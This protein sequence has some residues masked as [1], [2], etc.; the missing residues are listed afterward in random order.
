[1]HDE[2]AYKTSHSWGFLAGLL[3]GLATGTFAALLYA[4]ASGRDARSYIAN[5]AR[6][7]RDRAASIVERGIRTMNDGREALHESREILS[8]ALREGREA[9]Q[10][11]K[12]SE[13]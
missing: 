7:G 4:P 3:V 2:D 11:A 10:H 13:A 9:Y 6:T 5:R 1:M 8:G 12:A